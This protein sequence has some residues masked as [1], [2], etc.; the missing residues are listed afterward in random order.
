MSRP[1]RAL[2]IF[3][4]GVFVLYTVLFLI[5]KNTCPS[6]TYGEWMI[7]SYAKRTFYTVC[8]WGA[9]SDQ[10]PLFIGWD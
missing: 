3:V 8:K 9:F 7:R 4:V 2:I 5:L 10:G 6:S 1:F